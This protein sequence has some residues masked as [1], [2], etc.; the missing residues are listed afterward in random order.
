M[1]CAKCCYVSIAQEMAIER[2][3]QSPSKSWKI[4]NNCID[5]AN[6][7][8]LQFFDMKKEDELEKNLL[9]TYFSKVIPE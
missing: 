1:I 3:K 4:I 7:Y 5:N 9:K 8:I 6:D 2:H